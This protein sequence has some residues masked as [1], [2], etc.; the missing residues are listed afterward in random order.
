[1]AVALP[2]LFA[3]IHH[4]SAYGLWGNRN[5]CEMLLTVTEV[6]C[7]EHLKQRETVNCLVCPGGIPLRSLPWNKE[8]SWGRPKALGPCPLPGTACRTG[9]TTGQSQASSDR[10]EKLIFF[11]QFH[12]YC[13]FS[14]NWDRPRHQTDLFMNPFIVDQRMPY[15]PDVVEHTCSPSHSRRCFQFT[16]PGQ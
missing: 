3:Q 16:S 10:R 12:L 11:C 4:I 6:N 9:N 1:M 7:Q 2:R 14:K 15:M 13:L 8:K 5:F